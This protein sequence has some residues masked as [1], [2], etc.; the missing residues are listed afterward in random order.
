VRHD[1]R[2]IFP[3]DAAIAQVLDNLD[4]EA[5]RPDADNDV[6]FLRAYL[7]FFSGQRA[8]AEA[9]FRN[10][11]AGGSTAHYEVFQ[12]AIERQRENR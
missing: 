9:V 4:R 2:S 1:L 11:P 7:L 5:R 3:D 6:D 8:A 10:P 12:Q